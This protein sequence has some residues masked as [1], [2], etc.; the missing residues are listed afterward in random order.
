M[1]NELVAI[2][3]DG[4]SYLAWKSALEEQIEQNK[5]IAK[6]KAAY[7]GADCWWCRGCKLAASQEWLEERRLETGQTK[8]PMCGYED[9]VRFDILQGGA[10]AAASDSAI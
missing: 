10:A 5:I 9:W 2:D 6:R 8:C 1:N 4:V 3:I 7:C